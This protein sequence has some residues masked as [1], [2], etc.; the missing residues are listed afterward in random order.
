MH[1]SQRLLCLWMH[2]QVTESGVMDQVNMAVELDYQC[3]TTQLPQLPAFDDT[4]WIESTI[5]NG[6]LE[7]ISSSADGIATP[8]LEYVISCWSIDNTLRIYFY[9]RV[10]VSSSGWANSIVGQ[11]AVSVYVCMLTLAPQHWLVASHHR[12]H[13]SVLAHYTHGSW[14]WQPIGCFST[15]HIASVILLLLLLLQNL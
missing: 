4:Q 2:W 1:I 13:G 9:R 11:K 10:V 3:P 5:H 15:C 14:A 6:E 12:C 8:F 7:L